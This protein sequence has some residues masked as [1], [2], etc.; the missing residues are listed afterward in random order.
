MM[1]LITKRKLVYLSSWY[2]FCSVLGLIG[3]IISYLKSGFSF[4]SMLGSF[5]IV[6]FGFGSLVAIVGLPSTDEIVK[7]LF[8]EYRLKKNYKLEG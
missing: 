8:I 1:S 3:E 4:W 2:S 5:V 7:E 6:V